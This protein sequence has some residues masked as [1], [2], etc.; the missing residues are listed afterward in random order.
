MPI[1]SHPT[2]T[3]AADAP[4]LHTTIRAAMV[5]DHTEVEQL[6]DAALAAFRAGDREGA[7]ERFRLFDERLEAHLVLEDAVLLPA[8]RRIDPAEVAAM[9]AD[10]RTFR[11]RL[12]AL[13]V[14]AALDATGAGQ[15]ADLAGPLAAHA[16]RE[17]ALLAR[18]TAEATADLACDVALRRL[19][20]AG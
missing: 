16:G 17:H 20:H 7:A 14:G 18:W 10:H 3:P 15:L 19:P 9:E 6:L 12:A 2:S 1:T 8:L 4:L 11:A 5:D 13:D